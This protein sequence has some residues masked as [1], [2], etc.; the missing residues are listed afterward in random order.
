MVLFSAFGIGFSQLERKFLN[1]S[2]M[3]D[4]ILGEML[5]LFSLYSLALL[6][7]NSLN[8]LSCHLV[9]MA[10]KWQLVSLVPSIE[11]LLGCVRTQSE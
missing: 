9:A 8:K 5:S 3:A 7:V 2:Q 6:A 4:L 10:T 1:F 11:T